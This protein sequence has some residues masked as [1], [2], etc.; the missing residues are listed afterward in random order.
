MWVRSHLTEYEYWWNQYLILSVWISHHLKQSAR[1]QK[2][3]LN[4]EKIKIFKKIALDICDVGEKIPLCRKIGMPNT[5]V[6]REMGYLT[7]ER[8]FVQK[9]NIQ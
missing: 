1:T 6:V 5:L 8:T 9:F 7:C 2:P 4:E 3:T